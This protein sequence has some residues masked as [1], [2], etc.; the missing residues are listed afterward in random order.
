MRTTTL[1]AAPALVWTLALTACSDAKA[2]S[3]PVT[4]APA[5]VT[6]SAVES[7]QPSAGAA[8]R[9]DNAAAAKPTRPRASIIA[10]TDAHKQTREFIGYY[11]SI[12]LTPEQERIKVAALSALPA[13]CCAK[14]TL[15][16]CCCPC[17]MSKAV[18]GMAAWLITE[19]GQSVEQVRQ[20]AVDWLAFIN[21]NGFSGEACLKG[22]CNRPAAH[23]GC[24]GMN[25]THL[26]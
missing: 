15:A 16:T 8:A 22:G 25:E 14:F 13:P 21:P 19:K 9:P 1:G 3:P 7:A 5:A 17:N 11:R 23:D 26:L 4:N 6:A 12:K 24:G 2:V 10:F 18:W 20:A